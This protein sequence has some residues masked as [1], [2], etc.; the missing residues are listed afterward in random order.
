[1]KE[2]DNPQFADFL[3]MLGGIL[4]TGQQ[5]GELDA[6]IPAH[7]AARMIFGMVDELALA[8]VLA[9]Q[10]S[11]STGTPG[12]RPKKFDIV[13]AADWVVALVTNGLQPK[14]KSP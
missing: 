11:I 4:A 12:T 8:W 7:V 10:P 9:R 5:R 2:Y 6:T 13:R 1:M 14:E 3:R